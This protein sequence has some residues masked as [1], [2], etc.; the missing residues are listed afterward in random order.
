[1]TAGS[2]TGAGPAQN[3]G[4]PLKV[5]VR[6]ASV[7]LAH[8]D[9][10]RLEELAESC[11]V[12]AVDPPDM[13]MAREAAGEM[14]ILGRLLEATRANAMVMQRLRALHAVHLEYSERQV[15]GNAVENAYGHN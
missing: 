3:A 2:G 14:E 15:R 7:A 1:M 6:E 11:H 13:R 4:S 5:M 8:L 10:A 12:L 9:A